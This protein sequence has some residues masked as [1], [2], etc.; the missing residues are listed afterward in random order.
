MIN[1]KIKSY[2]TLTGIFDTICMYGKYKTGERGG[3]RVEK[4]AF[5]EHY[6]KVY[7]DMYR[8][9]LYTLR[10]EADA[11]D[12]VSEAVMD[13][14]K[15]LHNLKDDGAFKNW[16][17]KILSIKCKRRQKEYANRVLSLDETMETFG[18]EENIP[19]MS[20]REDNVG[21]TFG[22]SSGWAAAWDVRGA[23]WQLAEEERLI[24]SMSVFGG[25]NSREIGEVLEMK[26]GSVR[27]RLSRALGKMQTRLEG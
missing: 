1:K 20:S 5:E 15:G 6:R 26:D 21:G 12:A 25:Y 11:E 10:H 27:S 16:I 18:G 23:F 4:S 14:W 3:T 7:Q 22:S 13:A 8:F 9:A 19:G 24:I 17:F 2:A